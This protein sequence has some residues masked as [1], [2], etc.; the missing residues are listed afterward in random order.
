[1]PPQTANG[2]SSEPS[3]APRRSAPLNRRTLAAAALAA[4]GFL[5]GPPAV[6]AQ[7]ASDSAG[8]YVDSI[9]VVGNARNTRETIINSAGIPTHQAITYR[10]VARGIQNLMALG[11]FDDVAI[12][13]RD[14]EHGEQILVIAV[15]ERP[16]LLRT[17]IRGVEKLSERSVRDRIDL[18]IGRPLDPAALAKAKLRIDSLYEDAGYYLATITADVARPDSGHAR[19]V[20]DIHEGRRVAIS[21]IDIQGN[22]DFTDEQIVGK[23]KTKPEGFWWFR[24]GDYSDDRLREDLESRLP[25][26]YGSHGYI[27]FR[28]LR[29][30]LLVDAANGKATLVVQIDEGRPYR[31]GTVD[32]DGNRYLSTQD[33]MALNP[34]AARPGVGLGC[35]V[36]SCQPDTSWFDETRWDAATQRLRTAYNNAGY[37]YANVSPDMQRVEPADTTQP[38]S[39]NLTWRIDEG[40]PAIVNRVDIVGNESTHERVIRDAIVILPG[41]VFAQDRV[42]K[43]YQNISNLGFFQQP[44]PFPDSRPVNQADPYSDIDLIFHVEEKHTGNVNFGASVG[45]GTGVGGFL[46]LDEP[47]LFGLGKRGQVQWQ[48]GQ[49]INDFNLTYTDPGISGSRI[50][51]QA[52]LENSRLRYTIADLGEITTRGGTI[53]LGF[54]LPRSRYSR[55]FVSYD[56]EVE[57]Y[58]GAAA[59]LTGTFNCANC[60]R[61][62]IDL[63]F[64]RDTR[65][66]M[67]FPTG[68][69]MHQATA[70]FTGGPLGG[71]AT[72]QRYDLEGRWYAPAGRLGGSAAYGSGIKLV[73]G[74]TTKAGFVFG[75]TGPFFRQLYTMG[76]TQYG[77]PL[78]GYD[79]FSITPNGFDPNASANTQVQESAFGRSYFASTAEFGARFSQQIYASMFYDAGNVWAEPSGFNPT[80][81]FRGAGFGVSLIT[82]LGPIGIDLAYGFDRTDTAGRPA[83]G[84]KVHFKVGNFF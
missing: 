40:R 27:D 17:A 49:N 66:D 62:A 80:R 36:H 79:E 26:F 52:T 61:S 14:G 20:F 3:P 74:L 70:S 75:N 47:N 22:H 19:V 56:L 32:V 6:R 51:G 39:V 38:P 33:V 42:I 72:F 8:A 55:L 58:T 65:V 37:I 21:A 34:F 81:L 68:G 78:R 54:P 45:Q 69:A 4:A 41:D 48:F 16:I 43:S 57:H 12:E 73:L 71:T 46:G 64:M 9:E 76:G 50:S 67:P 11:Q 31:V 23:L 84:W 60:L 77:I 35:V 1:M 7:A 53:Q 10:D 63:S 59:A 13:R 15:R 24:R 28:V 5:I 82:P 29:D 30:T 83:P 18:P 25:A 2:S 44:L